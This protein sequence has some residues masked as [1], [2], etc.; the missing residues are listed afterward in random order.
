MK[1]AT[2]AVF[3]QDNALSLHTR[4]T[5]AARALSG[6]GPVAYLDAGRSSPW[7]AM[8]AATPSILATAF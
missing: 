2:V 4:R 8:P 5:D 6:I 7:H 3:S 1:I